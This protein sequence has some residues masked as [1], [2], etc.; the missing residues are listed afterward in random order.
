MI[1]EPV[2][3]K[4]NRN[5]IWKEAVA[6]LLVLVTIVLVPM[7]MQFADAHYIA[8]AAGGDKVFDKIFTLS[9]VAGDGAWTLE[10]VNGLNYWWQTFDRAVLYVEQG[11]HVLL[12]LQST[13]VHHRFYAP[14]LGIDPVDIEP[15][16]TEFV[17]FHARSVG[18]YRYYCT[19]ICG[20]CHFNMS[21]WIVVSPKGQEPQPSP[22]ELLAE[23]EC[24]EHDEQEKPDPKDMIQWGAYLHGQKGCTTCHG[25]G[26]IGDVINFNYIK[27]TVPA[28]NTLAEKLFL[29]EKEDAE[30]FIELLRKRTDFDELT[31]Q[32]A[33]PRFTLVLTQY[34]AA[35]ALIINGKY[36]AKRDE[37]GPEPPLQMPSWREVLNDYDVDSLIAYML[38]IYPWE[39]DEEWEDEQE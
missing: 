37:D 32:P 36:C 5:M 1:S 29:E 35:K 11:D 23:S 9:G 16:H 31:E 21:G 30:A 38:S 24:L 10:T 20:D 2:L 4:N 7:A 17:R 12:R 28:H 19:S 39:D 33:I 14:A 3:Q 8:L 13:D 15:G 34:K 27:K 18:T 25:K 26:G 6:A 22:A